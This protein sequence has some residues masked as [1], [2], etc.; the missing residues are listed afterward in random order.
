MDSLLSLE[1][2]RHQIS[3]NYWGDFESLVEDYSMYQPTYF[4][5]TV[6]SI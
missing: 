1:L 4:S 3:I 2:I 5:D 6:A